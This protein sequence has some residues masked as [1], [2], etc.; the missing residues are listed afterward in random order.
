[1]LCGPGC[2]A[3]QPAGSPGSSSAFSTGCA[4]SSE[5]TST[6]A[7]CSSRNQSSAAACG[8]AGG[9]APIIRLRITG[10]LS[11]IVR[12]T[13]TL[14]A[15]AFVTHSR[16]LWNPSYLFASLAPLEQSF[17]QPAGETRFMAGTMYRAIL[18]LPN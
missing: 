5:E 16:S 3:R 10:H 8:A 7:T 18:L 2:P 6:V 9:S 15:L 11:L 17:I 1:M 12:L 14:W 13:L 4:D